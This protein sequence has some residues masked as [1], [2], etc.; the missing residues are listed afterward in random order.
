VL[1]PTTEK[2]CFE[3]ELYAPAGW[4]MSADLLSK[5]TDNQ[6][7]TQK[8]TVFEANSRGDAHIKFSA[9]LSLGFQPQLTTVAQLTVYLS[10]NVTVLNVSFQPYSC[11]EQS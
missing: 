11:L 2:L 10:A 3:I 9:E 7:L 4:Q 5:V 8:K 1:T 6:Q